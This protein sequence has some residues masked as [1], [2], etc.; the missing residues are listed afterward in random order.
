MINNLYGKLFEYRGDSS[1]RGIINSVFRENVY[2][3]P[4]E[5]EGM[6]VIDIGAQIGAASILAA[7]R[8]AIVYAYEPFIDNYK[9]LVKNIAHNKYKNKIFPFKEAVGIPGTR[10]LY[11]HDNNTGSN[12]LYLI[13]PDFDE[14][15]YEEIKTVSLA[16]IFKKH[17]IKKCDFLKLDCE[18]AE[19][20]IIPE[21]INGLHEKID[22]I[23]GEIH[24]DISKGPIADFDKI[25]RELMAGLNKLYKQTELSDSEFLW[26]K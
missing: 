14:E 18:G 25:E 24:I 26:E 20:E 7:S 4:E 19:R 16:S 15:H 8:G 2:K 22:K 6:M 17:N 1:D 3:M 23:G 13:L 21:I 12:S 10:K 11:I 9:L 5:M